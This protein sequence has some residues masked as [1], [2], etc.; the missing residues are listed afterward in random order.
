MASR[1][2]GWS[3]TVTRLRASDRAIPVGSRINSTWS[4]CSVRFHRD[5]AFFLPGKAI[6]EVVVPDDQ[7]AVDVTIIERDSE[8]PKLWPRHN[9]L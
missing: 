8:C 4:H 3:I 9:F 6:V 7:R 2:S 1:R 5:R